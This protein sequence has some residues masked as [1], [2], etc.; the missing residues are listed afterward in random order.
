[1]ADRGGD[2]GPEGLR[3]D[4]CGAV[5]DSVRRI[6]LDGSYDRLVTPHRALYACAACSERKEQARKGLGRRS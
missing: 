6:A 2:P 5:V 3:C 4:F 1:M